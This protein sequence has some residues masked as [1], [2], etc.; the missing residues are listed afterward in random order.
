LLEFSS[1]RI[2]RKDFS[3]EDDKAVGKKAV[4]FR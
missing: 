1:Q 2:D 4:I 3:P